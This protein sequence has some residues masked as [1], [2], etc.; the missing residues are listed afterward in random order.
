MT[1]SSQESQ[2]TAERAYRDEL[3]IVVS[4]EAY[5]SLLTSTEGEHVVLLTK[6]PKLLPVSGLQCPPIVQICTGHIGSRSRHY[7]CHLYHRR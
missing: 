6:I 5:L 3:E 4:T 1:S 7:Q 2:G